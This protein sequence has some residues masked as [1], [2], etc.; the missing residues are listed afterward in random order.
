MGVKFNY[1]ISGVMSAV[2]A[3]N[4]I[5]ITQLQ[6]KS[7]EEVDTSITDSLLGDVN[8]D[9]VVNALDVALLKN[10]LAGRGSITNWQNADL[11]G[12]GIINIYDWCLLKSNLMNDENVQLYPVADPVVID[13][14]QPYEYSGY[15]TFHVKYAIEV[16]VKLQY[17]TNPLKVWTIEDFKNIDNIIEISDD[18]FPENKRQHLTLI[19]NNPSMEN[20]LKT[21]HDI[22]NLNIPEIYTVSPVDWEHG[23]PSVPYLISEGECL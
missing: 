4:T 8:D 22:E 12:D 6:A 11:N 10:W 14:F 5:S 15:D 19:I 21:I 16:I 23:V 17:T 20:L 3:I 13:V 7:V 18:T 2:M 9:G 1:L